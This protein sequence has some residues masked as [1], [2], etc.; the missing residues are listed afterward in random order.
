MSLN[1]LY[2]TL[3]FGAIFDRIKPVI[4][5]PNISFSGILPFW[6]AHFVKN[7][8][9]PFYITN[10]EIHSEI[11]FDDASHYFNNTGVAYLPLFS[12]EN[13][14]NRSAFENH[15][16]H[17][18]DLYSTNSLKC[19]IATP[20]L[21]SIR[22]PSRE[23]IKR[24]KVSI[25]VN[26]NYQFNWVIAKLLDFGYVRSNEVEFTGQFT[27]RG[28]IIDIYPFGETYPFRLEFFGNTI[29][30]IRR[31]NPN[32]QNSID[33]RSEMSFLPSS[34]ALHEYNS[35]LSTLP[36]NTIFIFADNEPGFSSEFPSF[37]AKDLYA[38]L[39]K[40][41]FFPF[42]DY[43]KQNNSVESAVSALITDNYSIYLIQDQGIYEH[44][45]D[46]LF[47]SCVYQRLK[48]NLSCGFI[49][50][51]AKWAIITE[52]ELF[53]RELLVNPNEKFIPENTEVIHTV[54]LLKYGDFIVHSDYGIGRFE[55]IQTIDINHVLQDVVI[56]EYENNDKVYVSVKNLNK[57]FKYTLT[58]EKTPELGRIG[59]QRWTTTRS[60]VRHSIREMAKDLVRL[61]GA[62]MEKP[63][64]AF[65][66]DNDDQE[67]LESS[68]PYQET[69]DQ[70]RAIQ[71]IKKDMESSKIMDR[72]ICGDVG[73]GKT[74]VAIRAAFKAVLSGKQ[75]AVLVPTTILSIQHYETFR[76]R[77][78]S[79]GVTIELYNRFRKTT[80][81]RSIRLKTIS[82][83]ADILIG[84]HKML[85]NDLMFKDLGLL[86]IDEEHRFGVA[87]KE[88]IKKIKESV[89]VITM[90][91]TPIPRTLEFSLMGVRDISKIETPPKERLPIHTKIVH[92][93]LSLIR[94]A[95]RREKERNGQVLFV[96][97]NISML[98]SLR[99][100][101]TRE[102]PFIDARFAH[103][104]MN[105]TEL[106][107]IL[108]SFY[109]N[110]FDLLISTTI[111]ESGI[112]IPNANTLFI[113]DAQTFGL[114][115]LY[116]IRGRVG[117]SHRRAY[118]Y[119]I[120][121]KNKKMNSSA[122]KRLKTLEYYTD[123]GSGYYVAMR[124]LEIRG[125]GNLF[126]TAQSG[127]INNI[128]YDYYLKILGEEIEYIRTGVE[129]DDYRPDINIGS[130]SFF[131][132]TYIENENQKIDLYRRLAEAQTREMIDLITLNIRDR[133][134]PLPPEAKNLI[135]EMKLAVLAKPHLIQRIR[136]DKNRLSIEFREQKDPKALQ[137]TLFMFS[138]R[139]NTLAK[140]INFLTKGLVKMNCDLSTENTLAALEVLLTGTNSPQSVEDAESK[141]FY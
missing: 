55:G 64:F 77:L 113:L 120:I 95:I 54:E 74:E 89:D 137:N 52:H 13:R 69:H 21:P 19:V 114:S 58:R 53:K 35:I 23:L 27:V 123:L 46:E 71:E 68:F 67:R 65:D 96:C 119:L 34:E 17:F 41:N 91:A 42:T 128:G 110:E 49:N 122:E 124:D 16:A 51:N 26:D 12:E 78:E 9:L 112:D 129:P 83:Q 99:D 63:G 37:Y 115:Q 109:H 61:Y 59:A 107:N 86:I 127:Y 141:G 102:C 39:L 28:G 106:E 30:S 40:D 118:A 25:Q 132:K 85:S 134:G 7:G 70:L 15:Y 92:F 4:E 138:A 117:R 88:K 6:L 43:I 22:I 116:Q 84:T 93:D 136:L 20:R 33:Q 105:G 47:V 100:Q 90:S 31:F 104:Q 3:H 45:I 98:P 36:S 131:P 29:E 81:I 57:I 97:N 8:F 111:I 139:A 66:A 60:K 50:H 87:D 18:N 80:D 79:F 1:Q 108:L 38:G 76:S 125:G 10:E 56:I 135:T 126:G 44:R 5:I 82:G 32:S 133:F 140:N 62:R 101:L 11:V 73:F 48:T 72:L 75:V 103:G 130:H 121:P 24:Y 94:D 14:F 2:T